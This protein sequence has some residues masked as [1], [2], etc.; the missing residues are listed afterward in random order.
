MISSEIV[1]KQCYLLD[2]PSQ[3]LKK[4]VKETKIRP[5]MDS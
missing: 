1:I 5:Q 3:K 2:Q 4:A